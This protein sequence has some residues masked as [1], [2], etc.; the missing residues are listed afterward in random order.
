MKYIVTLK[1]YNP[2]D[3]SYI[4]KRVEVEAK[5]YED[6]ESQVMYECSIDPYSPWM[7]DNIKRKDCTL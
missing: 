2:Y 7:L 6:A 3:K 4:R 1:A 5:S